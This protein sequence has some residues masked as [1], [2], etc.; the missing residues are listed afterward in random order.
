MN[1]SPFLQDLRDHML[2]MRYSRRTVDSYIHWIKYFIV[3][4]KKQ[5]PR[6][7][8]AQ[9]VRQFISHL[10]LNREV[11]PATQAIALNALSYLFNKYL[12]LPLGEIGD[13]RKPRRQSKLPVVLSQQE[14]KL[15]FAQL[16]GTHRLM[17]GLLYGSGLRRIELVRLRVGD[18]D[19]NHQQVRIWNGKGYKHRIATLAPELIPGL[20]RQ[21]AK[22]EEYLQCDLQNP[23]YMGVWMPPALSRKYQTGPK[24]LFWHYLFPSTRLSIEPNTDN[25]RRHHIDETA[26]GKA[27]RAAA[28]RANI[29]KPVSCHTLRHSFATHLLQAGA[30]IR[31]VQEQLGHADVKTTEIYTHVLNR[32]AKGVVSP[33]SRLVGA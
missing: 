29:Q 7:L 9:D 1:N 11:S 21:C 16:R 32:G 27:I 24:Q 6:M 14:I 4:H 2:T 12:N 15:L 26:P 28:R 20:N 30:D 3:F 31:T 10:A 17:A 13:F 23:D 5:H 19:F 22:V 8:G 33:L 25:L 18:F